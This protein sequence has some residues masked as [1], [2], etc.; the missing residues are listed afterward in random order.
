MHKDY[1]AIIIGAGIGGLVCGC[2]LAKAGKKVLII[3]RHHNPGGY[4]QSFMRKGFKFDA[5]VHSLGSCRE[6][7]QLN[8]VFKDLQLD[9]QLNVKRADPSDSI[10][11]GDYSIVLRNDIR[12]TIDSFG[13]AFP[14]ERNSIIH[15]F[16]FVAK[17]NF[18]AMYAQLR[19]KTFDDLLNV[20]FADGKLKIIIGSFLGN[21]GLP[22]SKASALTGAILYREFVLD[23]GYYLV[24]GMQ[25]FP[26]AL[27]AKFK[28]YGGEIL[29]SCMA[30]KILV[31]DNSVYGVITD[32]QDF[33]ASNCVVSACDARQTFLNLIGTEYLDKPFINKINKMAVSLSVFIVYVGLN[34][35]MSDTLPF[36]CRTLLYSPTFFDIN[37]IHASNLKGE[38]DINSEHVVCS[39]SSLYDPTFAKKDKESF[40]ILLNTPFKTDEY[41][42]SERERLSAMLVQRLE[43]I[44][45][46][47]TKHVEFLDTA[48]PQ[49]LY[50]YTLN[51]KGA[52]YGW[53]STPDQIDSSLVPLKS[54]IKGLFL[55]GHWSTLGGGQGGISTTA[56]S[57]FTAARLILRERA[58]SKVTVST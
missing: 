12:A 3:E 50:R 57:G 15:F 24:G 35:K 9:K 26:D 7:G 51:S 46:N 4:C 22:S 55:A 47:I 49:T 45:P 16:D 54:S 25:A 5:C 2:Y 42:V 41:W 39:F 21:V 53:A 11:I 38:V 30:K 18:I 58:S 33:I 17:T 56:Y 20:Y 32:K 31:K 27:V 19:N 14:K 36:Q 37:K 6:G 13:Q 48:T 23:G 52:A 44:M 40:F 29:F 8:K 1:D 10:I 43:K 34:K 28:E